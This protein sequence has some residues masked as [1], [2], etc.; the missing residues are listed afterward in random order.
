MSKIINIKESIN[1]DKGLISLKPWEFRKGEWNSKFFIQVLR[2]HWHNLEKHGKKHELPPLHNVIRDSLSNTIYAMYGNRDNVEKMK[3]LYYLAGLVDCMINQ[4]NP[5]L[6][7]SHINDMYKKIKTFKE[8]L[9]VNWYGQMDQVLF[10]IDKEFYN[11]DEYRH[12]LH[13][14]ATMKELYDFIKE[15]TFR[16]FDFLSSEYIFFTPGGEE[17]RHGK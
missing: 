1:R 6:R 17:V 13:K 16:M 11:I 15:G 3:E 8:I 7:T 10:P 2:S 5:L 14:A 12:R 9:G 4:T